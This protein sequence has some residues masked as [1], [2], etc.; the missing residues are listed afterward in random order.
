MGA[1]AEIHIQTLCRNSL[2]W[3]FPTGFLASGMG[4]LSGGEGN[5]VGIKGEGNHKENAVHIIN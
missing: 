2:I 3:K 4:E 1:D 5:I